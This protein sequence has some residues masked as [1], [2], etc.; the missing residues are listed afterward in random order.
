MFPSQDSD[1]SLAVTRAAAQ[2]G[3]HLESHL[4]EALLRVEF[5]AA[6]VVEQNPL[7]TLGE[8]RLMYVFRDGGLRADDSDGPGSAVYRSGWVRAV[9]TLEHSI[10]LPTS[11]AFREYADAGGL[12]TYGVNFANMFRRAAE[13]IDRILKGANPRD[14]P[15]EQPTRFE[16]VINLKTAK[17]L[18]LTI[19]PS[20][21]LRAD[22]LIE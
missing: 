10:R 7:A 12:V 6:R 14:L 8:D 3:D 13:Y 11:F 17:A 5:P 18:G 19:P 9:D 2:L 4:L 15:V 21:L 20:L 1:L 16:L 22:Q